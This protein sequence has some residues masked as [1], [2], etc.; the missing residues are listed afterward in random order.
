MPAAHTNWSPPR[1][2]P[3]SRAYWAGSLHTLIEGDPQHIA[4]Q[5]WRLLVALHRIP[6]EP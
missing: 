1:W 6:L 2:P 4:A 3:P 5:L